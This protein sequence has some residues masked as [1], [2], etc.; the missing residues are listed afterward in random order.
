MPSDRA[1]QALCDI[2]ENVLLGREFV[3]GMSLAAFS[4]DRRTLYAVTRCL[5]IISEGARRLTPTMRDR[6]PSLP[7]RAIMGIGNVYR[8][9]YDN[10]AE[11]MVWNTVAQSLTPLLAMVEAELSHGGEPPC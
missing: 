5:E 4:A 6:H 11:S 7:W 1:H 9:D 2:R 8:H 3:A 10:V